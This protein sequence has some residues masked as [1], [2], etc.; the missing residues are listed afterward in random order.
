MFIANVY[1]NISCVV[2]FSFYWKPVSEMTSG[3]F[4]DEESFCKKF[5]AHLG[6]E[7]SWVVTDYNV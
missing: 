5:L 4:Y 1:L 3:G 6:T 7:H 2:L